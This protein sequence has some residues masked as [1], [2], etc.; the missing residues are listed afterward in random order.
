MNVLANAEKGAT[1]TNTQM[2]R[3]TGRSPGFV[4]NIQRDLRDEGIMSLIDAAPLTYAATFEWFDGP[5]A[6]KFRGTPEG[7]APATE[8][9]AP[10]ADEGTETA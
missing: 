5:Q 9:A 4:A 10:S 6:A 3:A 8:D 7:T 2:G 1:F